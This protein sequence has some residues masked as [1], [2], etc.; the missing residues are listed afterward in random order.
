MRPRAV[1]LTLI[2]ANILT[3]SVAWSLLSHL[4]DLPPL[5]RL[6]PTEVTCSSPAGWMECVS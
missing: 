5:R 6:G 2:L 1:L 3:W 4:N